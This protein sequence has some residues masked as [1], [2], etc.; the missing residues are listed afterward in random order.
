MLLGNGCN[1]TDTTGPEVPDIPAGT[2]KAALVNTAGKLAG[3]LSV[4]PKTVS[5]GGFAADIE[6][7]VL[8][9][10]PSTT[11]TVQRA[12]EIGRVLGS[13]G[14]C[15]RAL[16][17]TPWSS[18]DPAAAAFLTFVPTGGST[19]ITLTTSSTGEGTVKFDFRATTIP[20]GTRFDVMFRLLDDLTAPTSILLSSC[21]TVLVL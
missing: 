3:G 7:H 21:F 12:P 10:R 14:S 16:G 13:D 6:V 5:E 2:H 1:S 15:Q 19:A 9:G 8:N 20:V 4:T 17:L 11:Y 18:S